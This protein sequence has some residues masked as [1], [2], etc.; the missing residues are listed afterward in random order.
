MNVTTLGLSFH[1]YPSLHFFLGGGGQEG[2]SEVNS[3]LSEIYEAGLWLQGA[4]SL[5][6][7]KKWDLVCCSIHAFNFCAIL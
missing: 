1:S 6:F 2:T 7:A 4:T 3:K 5:K